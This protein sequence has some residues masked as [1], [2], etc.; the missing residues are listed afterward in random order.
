MRPG[1]PWVLLVCLC[2]AAG[3]AAA[4]PIEEAVRDLGAADYPVRERAQRDLVLAG[5]PAVPALEAALQADDLEVRVRAGEILHRILRTEAVRSKAEVARIL[6]EPFPD[7]FRTG[8]VGSPADVVRLLSEAVDLPMVFQEGLPPAGADPAWG[9]PEGL[10]D[11]SRKTEPPGG[12]LGSLSV[13]AGTVPWRFLEDYLA[14]YEMHPTV[15]EGGV[16]ISRRK[17]ATLADIAPTLLARLESLEETERL[18]AATLLRKLT[19]ETRGYDPRAPE[20]E[21]AHALEAWKAWW[22]EAGPG[23]RKACRAGEQ[24]ALEAE[25]KALLADLEA[26]ELRWDPS[27]I[28]GF[29][30]HCLASEGPNRRLAALA[31]Y[32]WPEGAL[33]E[34]LKRLDSGSPNARCF[35][36]SVLGRLRHRP[37]LARIAGFLED[38]DARVAQIAADALGRMGDPEAAD[39]LRRL[40]A[41]A[42]DGVTRTFAAYNLGLLGQKDAIPFLFARIGGGERESNDAHMCLDVLL[43]IQLPML[44]P[45][46]AGAWWASWWEGNADRLVWDPKGCWFTVG[47]KPEGGKE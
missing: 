35:A 38:P 12:P 29:P 8:T 6:G 47:L 46:E 3:P 21:R 45:A 32:E 23:I 13:P 37:A 40:M 15:V 2:A 4:G 44:P 41:S 14:T 16:F 30:P 33:P 11:A 5:G 17:A 27:F 25:L 34:I 22:Y 42:R 10:Q 39:A 7:G 28:A 31:A 36:I 9:G 24:P 1:T 43:D 26:R 20:P 19:G 18:T